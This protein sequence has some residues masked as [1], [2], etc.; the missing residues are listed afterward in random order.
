VTLEMGHTDIVRGLRYTDGYIL[1]IAEQG[2]L[3]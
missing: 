1:S 3:M 2:R